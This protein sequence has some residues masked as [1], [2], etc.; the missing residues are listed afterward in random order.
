MKVIIKIKEKYQKSIWVKYENAKILVKTTIIL[1]RMTCQQQNSNILSFACRLRQRKFP[2]EYDVE[3]MIHYAT[4]SL[5][6]IT[7]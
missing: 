4:S 6:G 5:L 1:L 3:H 7:L 2:S